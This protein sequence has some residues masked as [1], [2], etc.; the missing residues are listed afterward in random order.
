MKK[1][2]LSTALMTVLM[3]GIA[4]ASDCADSKMAGFYAGPT[5]G[6]TNTTSNFKTTFVDNAGFFTDATNEERKGGYTSA[7]LGLVAGWGKFW[8]QTYWGVEVNTSYNTMKF[9]AV[10]KATQNAWGPDNLSTYTLD[11]ER[12]W[13]VGVAARMGRMIGSDT[14]LYGRLGVDWQ[15]FKLTVKEKSHSKKWAVPVLTPGLGIEH[16]VNDKW[17]LRGDVSYG[18]ALSKKSETKDSTF[19]G[20]DTTSTESFRANNLTFKVGITYRF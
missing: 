13:Q 16:N 10:T 9:K 6:V 5:L 2:L 3:A 14:M 8:N 19:F 20:V 18:F 1:T 11:L 12:D 7:D 4:S 17:A 15:W